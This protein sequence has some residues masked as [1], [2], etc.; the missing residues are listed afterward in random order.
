MTLSHSERSPVKVEKL[1]SG[2]D[3]L[4]VVDGQA[5]FVPLS[6]PGDVVV[7][8]EVRRSRGT[9]FVD[10]CRIV[11][12]S[13]DR[14]PPPCPYFGQCGGCNWMHLPYDVQLV[15]KRAI[16]VET[17]RRIGGLDIAGVESVRP[18]A[19]EFGWRYRARIHIRQ[20]RLG[21]FRRRSHQLVSWETCLVLP[22]TLNETVRVLRD[23]AFGET[24]TEK[25]HSIEVAQSPVDGAVSLFWRLGA[26]A[27][28]DGM[29]ELLH[30]VSE[31][32]ADQ[33]IFCAGQ[34]HAVGDEGEPAAIT[35]SPLKLCEGRWS[36][37]ASPGTFFQVNPSVNRQLV[38]EVLSILAEDDPG[39]VLDLY[40]GNGNFS[41]PA[42]GLGWQ[43]V[44][45]DSSR[46]ATR[47]AAAAA[48][49][50]VRFVTDDVTRYVREPDG[51][52]SGTVIADPPRT[53][54]PGAVRRVL[55][56][57]SVKNLI[58]I[59]CDA[60]SMARDLMSLSDSG[61]RISRVRI[62]DMFPNSDHAET[63][64]HLVG[65]NKSRVQGPAS[66]G[67]ERARGR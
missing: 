30:R 44:G 41:I 43:V 51:P 33:G 3:G 56:E 19:S 7:P 21:F 61:Y 35:G 32:L 4:G 20:G 64:V 47:D 28:S 63:L 53:G 59:S 6:A 31:A 1:V 14:R 29:V 36:T 10:S 26:Q 42:A 45:V 48:G 34:G 60:A 37:L 22:E 65:R 16:V 23:L 17:A 50:A 12:E 46:G 8:T 13:P 54:L 40:C 15:W 66:R 58:Y 39:P 49:G 18:S 5:V 25:I 9:L 52:V 67:R 27:G 38:E 11:V 24:I 2:G 57:W 55:G 62:F